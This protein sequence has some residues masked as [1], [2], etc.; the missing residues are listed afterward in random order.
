[1]HRVGYY[2][3]HTIHNVYFWH[4]EHMVMKTIFRNM[5]G[6]ELQPRI[7]MYFIW[8]CSDNNTETHDLRSKGKETLCSQF[9]AVNICALKHIHE[10]GYLKYNLVGTRNG[11]ANEIQTEIRSFIKHAPEILWLTE[12]ISF[13]YVPRNYGHITVILYLYLSLKK[14]HCCNVQ[15]SEY[16]VRLYVIRTKLEKRGK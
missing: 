5:S 9:L 8:E 13:T 16:F 2:S 4:K 12:R 3:Y 1:V 15:M 6:W 7:S 11:I 14:H 10:T